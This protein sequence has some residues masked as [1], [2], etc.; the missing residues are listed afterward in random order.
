MSGAPARGFAS[1]GAA[2]GGGMAPVRLLVRALL[3]EQ[4][5][6]LIVTVLAIALGVALGSAVYLVNQAALEEFDAAASRLV[7]QADILVRGPPDGF[8]ESL[9]ATLARRA[10]IEVA[11]P[12]LEIEAA[13]PGRRDPLKI[14]GIDPFRAGA[15]QPEL[16]GDLGPHTLELLRPRQIALSASAAT[17]LGLESGGTL[18]LAVGS[19][20]ER[21]HVL[22]VLAPSTYGSDL[23][24]M[25][26]GSAQWLF[27]RL[28]HVNR[29][30][31]RLKAG[32]DRTRFRAGLALPPGVLAVPAALERDRPVTATRAYRTNLDMLALVSLFTGAFLVFS[33][34]ALTVLRRRRQLALLRALG[35][36]RRELERALLGEAL[37]IGLLGSL[38]G[39]TLAVLCAAAVLRWLAGDLGNLHAAGAQLHLS[40]TTLAAFL[41]L[42]TA[43]AALGAWWPAR[44]AARQP[45]A[46][47]LKGGDP[48]LD[49]PGPTRARTGLVLLALGAVLA[50]LPP[51]A[52]LPLYGYGAIAALLVGAVALVPLPTLRLLEAIPP[53]HRVVLDTAIAQLRDNVTLSTLGLTAIIV[54]FS[55]M[56]AMAIMVHSFRLSFEHWLDRLLPADLQLREPFGNDTA[57]LSVAEQRCIGA[58]PGV[59]RAEFRRT[60]PLL[61]GASR[62][63]VTLIARNASASAVEAELPLV[64]APVRPRAGAPPAWVSEPLAAL[65]GYRPGDPIVLPLGGAQRR[66]SIAGVWRDYARPFGAVVIARPAY[67]ELTGDERANEGSLWLEG[68]APADRVAAGVRRCLPS[69]TIELLTSTAL[70]ERSLAIF[71]R[72]F[73]ITYALEAVAVLIGL[74]GIS[75]AAASNALARRAEFG[76][77]RHLGLRRAE[78]LEM[79]ASEG[80]VLG[81]LG[82]LYGA[83]LGIVLSAVLVFV[84]NRQSFNWSIDLSIPMG[85]LL[86]LSGGLIGAAALTAVWSGRAA[87]GV[88]AVRAVRED[89]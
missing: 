56:V 17:A 13:L 36:T 3:R 44:H 73:A 87:V 89:W 71:D 88:E 20:V 79:L 85:Q 1:Q 22:A 29:I 24:L 69:G 14:L 23:G 25:D 77:L 4:P 2:H 53:S 68:R 10:D 81:G 9:Y 28:G 70:R 60:R 19:R 41:V 46:P 76:V 54:S 40:A 5:G 31:L 39:L 75:F 59:G 15:L 55:L 27:E 49:R 64:G 61:L 62:P 52:G 34:Q 74:A 63:P 30:D 21:L 66:F 84:V 80:L 37:L 11:S 83:L 67:I 33:T 18:E 8:D 51:V 58:L 86:A 35:V 12:V 72:A 50:Q 42:G 16:I 78:V 38:A 48:A 57:Y 32:V 26:I 45:P 47:A 65:Y 43:V 82:V 6:R 7:G